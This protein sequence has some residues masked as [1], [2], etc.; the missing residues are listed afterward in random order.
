MN[1]LHRISKILADAGLASRRKAEEIIREGRVTVNGRVAQVGDKADP[2]KDHIKVDGRRVLPG[3]KKVYIL[4][5]KPKG[6]VTSTE[7]PEGRTTVLD[8]IKPLKTRLFPVG[9]LDFDAEGVLLLTNDGE[10]AH[11]LTHP[12]F[13]VPRKYLVKIKG[14]P[15]E[16]EIEKLRQGIK[17]ADGHTAPCTIVPFQKTTENLWFEMTL[18]EGRNRQI[19]RMWEKIGYQVLKL[20]RIAFAG[21]SL[22]RM[23]PGEYRFLSPRE[24]PKLQKI[25]QNKKSPPGG[26]GKNYGVLQKR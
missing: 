15:A 22:G 18:Y 5:Y 2:G 24:L 25:I 21:L 23:R 12:S 17:L 1:N 20:K 3:T 26:G 6:V 19:K 16:E 10:A 7:D 9:R 4:L 13:Q 8:L 14:Q 11:C